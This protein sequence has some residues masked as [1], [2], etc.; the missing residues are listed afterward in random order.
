MIDLD[1]VG[2]MCN[3]L[4]MSCTIQIRIFSTMCGALATSLVYTLQISTSNTSSSYRVKCIPVD[5]CFVIGLHL[6]RGFN[7]RGSGHLSFIPGG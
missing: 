2:W 7:K 6:G 5:R 4:L 1:E 3:F